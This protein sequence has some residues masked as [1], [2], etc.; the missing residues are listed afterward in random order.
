MSHFTQIKTKAINKQAIKRALKRLYPNY[1]VVEDS[2]V[3]GWMGRTQ[4]ADVVLKAK[5][6]DYDLGFVKQS[7]GTFSSV[8]ESM[9]KW[10]E[11]K[12]QESFNQIY[13]VEAA[14][15]QAEE[16]GAFVQE[17]VQEDGSIQLHIEQF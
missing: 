5:Q 1:E 4:K 17:Q 16:L 10:K 8:A 7:D 2:V 9:S 14:K 3:R 11:T 15:M 12:F 6:G 13:A